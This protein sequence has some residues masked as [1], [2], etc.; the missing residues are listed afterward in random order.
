[1][2]C[3]HKDSKILFSTG[4][5]SVIECRIC[6]FR[7]TFPLPSENEAQDFYATKFYRGCDCR[8]FSSFFEV[9]VK[10]FRFLRACEIANWR[11]IDRVLDVGCGRGLMLFVSGMYLSILMMLIWPW[12]HP[13]SCLEWEAG[14]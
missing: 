7:K 6:G 8:R 13:I 1:M 12:N 11:G 10:V 3:K 2:F 5:F 9:L 14:F 4:A